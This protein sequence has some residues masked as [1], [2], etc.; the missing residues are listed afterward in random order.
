MY[1]SHYLFVITTG[2]M[3]HHLT[4]KTILQIIIFTQGDHGQ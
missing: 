4:D 1:H 2:H 3:I